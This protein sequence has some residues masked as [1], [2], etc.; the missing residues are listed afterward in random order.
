MAQTYTLLVVDDDL[1]TLKLVGTTLEKQGFNIVAAKDGQEALDR[2]AET[3]PDLILL[4]VMM[5]KMDGYEVTRRLRANPDTAGIPII[6]FTAKAQVDDKVAGLD[7]GADDYLTKPTHPAELVARV[8]NILKRPVTSMLPPLPPEPAAPQRSQPAPAAPAA[9]AYHEP[10]SYSPAPAASSGAPRTVLGVLAAKGGQGVSTLCINLAAGFAE[11]FNTGCILAELTPGHG[12]LNIRLG[13]NGEGLVELLRRTTRDIYRSAVEGALTEHKSNQRVLL[14]GI[15]PSDIALA[16]AGEQMA[17]I[18]SE[19]KQIS[20][21][22]VLDLGVGLPTSSQRAL[23]HCTHILVVA[24]PDPNSVEQTRALLHDLDGM[25]L[26]GKLMVVMVH[27]VRNDLAV[28]AAELQKQLER[29]LEAVFTPAPE[30]AHQ[31]TRQQQ[32]MLETDA[33]SYTAQQTMKLVS[34]I[35]E[36]KTARRR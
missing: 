14:A 35:T 30:L 12:D 29:E 27:R 31:A 18:V 20:D 10:A 24:E 32:S 33:Q 34:L 1:D 22:V 17:A 19:L 16:Q 3:K 6:L 15:R 11:R 23:E 5:P 8:R 26:Q 21:H 4:D 25:R 36:P 13:L 9:P 7:A 2:V 28:N